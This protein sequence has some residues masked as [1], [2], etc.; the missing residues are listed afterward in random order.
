M[1]FAGDGF[2]FPRLWIIPTGDHACLRWERAVRSF[3]HRVHRAPACRSS[4]YKTADGKQDRTGPGNEHRCDAKGAAPCA[5]NALDADERAFAQAAAWIGCDPRGSGGHRE[6]H[7][8]GTGSPR[9]SP[10]GCSPRTQPLAQT[11]K[12]VSEGLES[13]E[14]HAR[15]SPGAN[16]WTA[17]RRDPPAN[18]ALPWDRGYSLAKAARKAIQSSTVEEIQTLHVTTPRPSARLL[19]LASA[20]KPM[21]AA[22]EGSGARKRFL[23][24][25]ALGVFLSRLSTGASLLTTMSTDFQSFTRAFAA[26]FLAPAEQIRRLIQEGGATIEMLTQEL[27]V[28][29]RTIRHQIDNHRLPQVPEG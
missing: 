14:K 27:G 2:V 23:Q 24:A 26:E 8:V 12:W 11:K 16:S 4:K 3:A 15:T 29:E 10:R 1:A 6:Q 7:S 17:P 19:G 5:W 18:G 9:E 21:C 22:P 20:D 25:R 13:L 28:S